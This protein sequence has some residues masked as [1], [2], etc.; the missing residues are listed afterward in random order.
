MNAHGKSYKIQEGWQ[1][2]MD[3]DLHYRLKHGNFKAFRSLYDLELKRL[4]FICYHITQD[5]ATA[6]P[7]LI[8]SWK[9]AIESISEQENTPRENFGTLVSAEILKR[10]TEDIPSDNDYEGISKPLILKQYQP[11]VNAIE[12]MEYKDRYIY[13]LTTFGGLNAGTLAKYLSISFEESKDF[14]SKINSKAQD[15]SEIKKIDFA[16][17]VRLSANFK[18]LNGSPFVNIDVPPFIIT[19]LEHDYQLVM[20]ETGNKSNMSRKETDKMKPTTENNTKQV[21]KKPASRIGFKYI[22][23]I[24]ITTVCLVGVIA[25]AVILPKALGGNAASTRIVN[26]TVEAV[27]QGNVTQ[28]IS[29][30]GTLTPVTK[31][32]LTS[33]KGGEVEEVNCTVGA[34]VEE[35]AVIATING[36]DIIA[37]CDG[38][39]LEL[40]IAVGDEVAKGGSVAMVMGKEGFTMGIAV[41][42][43]EIS[44]VAI[45]QAVTFTIDALSKDYTGKVTDISY[46]GSSGGGSVAFQITATV[47]YIEGVYYP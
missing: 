22:K 4:W 28:T 14:I 37:P 19:T 5:V 3:Y 6:A 33:S 23:P 39:L 9:A 47:D 13:L 1:S 18:S 30:S 36:E 20:K 32:T 45:D 8:Q 40:P 41:D 15:T 16:L 34:A 21:S 44:S 38:I 11:Y 46:N 43:T 7:L 27:T 24:V 29:G 12:Q 2:Y 25:A 31:E 42:E 10:M 17:G 26:Y 35:D